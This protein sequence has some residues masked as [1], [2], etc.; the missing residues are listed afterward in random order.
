V[1][2]LTFLTNDQSYFAVAM[3]I[4][5]VFDFVE[6]RSSLKFRVREESI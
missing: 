3:Q 6:F 1:Q 2:A 5:K 4:D